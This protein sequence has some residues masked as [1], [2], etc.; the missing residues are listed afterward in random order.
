MYERV[1]FG[2]TLYIQGEPNI[3]RNRSTIR[4]LANQCL[5]IQSE[6]MVRPHNWPKYPIPPSCRSKRR[7]RRLAR[8]REMREERRTAP[9]V[10]RMFSGLGAYVFV[11][12][13][14]L[15]RKNSSRFGMSTLSCPFTLAALFPSGK[16]RMSPTAQI[17]GCDS[18]CSVD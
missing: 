17:D 3:R 13:A 11:N 14:F 1:H 6:V 15:S 18:N 9:L 5:M 4:C 10:R 7:H 12:L 2:P 16:S 8:R